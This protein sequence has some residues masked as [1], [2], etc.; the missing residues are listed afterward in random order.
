MDGMSYF[1]ASP[2][3]NTTVPK[4]CLSYSALFGFL[5]FY[6]EKLATAPEQVIDIK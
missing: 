4:L 1:T 5:R 2:L 3:M 6:S